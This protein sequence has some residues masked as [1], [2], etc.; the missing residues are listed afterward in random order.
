MTAQERRRDIEKGNALLCSRNIS[1]LNVSVY[2][3]KDDIAVSSM[4]HFVHLC[5]DDAKALRDI[6][7]E[8]YP[9]E[10]K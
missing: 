1:R 10:G 4:D 8:L 6:L 7:N 5:N 2:I 9:K 3:N